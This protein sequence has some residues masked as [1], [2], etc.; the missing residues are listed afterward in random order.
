[1]GEG[2]ALLDSSHPGVLGHLRQHLRRSRATR[3]QPTQADPPGFAAR[4]QPRKEN[5]L[6][7]SSRTLFL[8]LALGLLVAW[9]PTID[10]AADA[11]IE[12]C[13]SSP[14]HIEV[15]PCTS[16]AGKFQKDTNK[17]SLNTSTADCSGMPSN[18]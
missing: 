14:H 15:T 4:P 3:G 5:T 8:A 17:G 16:D 2:I 13:T 12:A 10:A 7:L 6:R 1:M 11:A 18:C 9:S